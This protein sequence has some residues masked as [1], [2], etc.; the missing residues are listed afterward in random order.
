MVK[1]KINLVAMK[2]PITRR[3]AAEI[4]EGL[5]QIDVEAELE[6][7]SRRK[8]RT[9]IRGG[10]FIAS[11]SLK[12]IKVDDPDAVFFSLYSC[13]GSNNATRFCDPG[14]DRMIERQSSQQDPSKRLKLVH[15]IDLRL[16]RN[17]A[18]PVIVHL[19]RYKAKHPYVKGFQFH[20][21]I[22]NSWRFQDVWLDK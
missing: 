19:M 21:G 11:M 9:K 4:I 10:D 6:I 22:Y 3:F 8:Y 14:L 20:H 15:E 17:F 13:G 5:K 2:T 7:P 16:Q 1:L 12:G 18:R